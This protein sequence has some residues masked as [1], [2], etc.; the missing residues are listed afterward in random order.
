MKEGLYLGHQ[1]F[2]FLGYSQSS[3]KDAT[4]WFV[5]PF[6]DKDGA[7]VTAESI[8]NSLGDFS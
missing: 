8:R 6:R 1:K 4:V 3:L 5:A 7:T 2:E